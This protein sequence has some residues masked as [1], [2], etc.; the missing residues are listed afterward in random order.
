MQWGGIT[1]Q[2]VPSFRA[3]AAHLY[4]AK[5]GGTSGGPWPRWDLPLG[6][7]SAEHKTLGV[8]P[9]ALG[10]VNNIETT[11]AAVIFPVFKET[12]SKTEQ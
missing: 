12:G 9:A 6:Q 10:A 3:C 5:G 11:S 7:S 8:V 1:S 4:R 2:P